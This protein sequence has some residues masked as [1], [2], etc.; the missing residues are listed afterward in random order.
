MGPHIVSRSS[1]IIV[2]AIPLQRLRSECFAREITRFVRDY[3]YRAALN[4][5]KGG[6]YKRAPRMNPFDLER[7]PVENQDT[8]IDIEMPTIAVPGID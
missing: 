6:S 4:F 2:L 3:G 8:S 1:T 7:I 5:T